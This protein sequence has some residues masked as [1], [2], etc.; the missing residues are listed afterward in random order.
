MRLNAEQRLKDSL[1]SLQESESRLTMHIENTP[2]GCI[3]WDCYCTEWNKSAGKI[4]GYSAEDIPEWCTS[5]RTPAAW[6]QL[7]QV[8]GNV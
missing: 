7:P 1:A 4:F 3:S 5:W 6:S 2:L 8:P